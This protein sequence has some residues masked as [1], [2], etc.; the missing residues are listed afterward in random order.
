MQVDLTRL[1]GWVK[2]SRGELFSF[3]HGLPENDYLLPAVAGKSLLE[4]QTHTCDC[5]RHWVGHV[6]SGHTLKAPLQLTN[7]IEVE[8]AFLAVDQLVDEAI[9]AGATGSIAWTDEE[10]KTDA[11]PAEW[12]L[13]HPMTHEFHHKG[14]VVLIAR[15]LGHSF[16]EGRDSDLNFPRFPLSH[17]R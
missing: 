13:L 2:Y 12:L 8:E 11:F 3:L 9:A 16:P 14:Q 7:L 1:Y 17:D 10:G 6:L 5:Y 4:I 15:M